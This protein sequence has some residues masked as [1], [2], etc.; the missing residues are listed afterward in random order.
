[1]RRKILIT[2]MLPVLVSIS[3]AAESKDYPVTPVPFTSVR[4]QDEFWFPRMET[5]RLVTVRADFKKCE[6]TGRIDNFAKAGGLMKGE[7]R[8]IPF[9]DSDVF[10]VIE[11]ASY[12]LAMHPDPELDKYL[13]EVIAK[14]AASQEPDGYLYTARKLI[15]PEKMPN[16]SGKERWFNEHSSHELYNVGHMY[17]GAVAHYQATGKRTFLDVAIKNADLICKEFGPGKHQNP[18]GHQEIEI[19]LCKL[20]RVTGQKKYL[21]TAKFLIDIRG[22]PETHKLYGGYAQDHKPVIEQDEAVG[23]AVRAGYL[24]SGMADVAAL[25]GDEAYLKAIDR[26]W[27]NVAFKKL[28]LTGGI[29]ARHGGEAFGD[30]YELPN[31]SAYNET[32]AAIANGLW[33]HRMFLLHGDAKYLDVLERVIYNGFLSGVEL[34]GDKFFYPNPLASEKGYKRSPWFGC[35]CCP[36]NIVRFIPSI[37]GYVY[38]VKEADLF[39]NLFIGGTGEIKMK[40]RV[41]KISQQTKYPW[42]G[43]VK[44][45]VDPEK[46]GKFGLNIRIPG[47]AQGRPVPGDLYKYL[48]GKNETGNVIRDEKPGIK[49][50][51]K[52]EE[53]NVRNGFAVMDREWAKGDVVELFLPMPIRRVVA[54]E[55]IKDDEGLVA[56][57]RGPVVYCLEG[58]DNNSVFSVVL[59]DDVKLSAEYRAD[60]LGGIVVI[61]GDVQV[62]VKDES[63]STATKPAGLLA[64]PYYSWCN[65]GPS[66]MNVWLAR[67]ADKARPVPAPTVASESKISASHLWQNDT[68][69][70]LNDQLMPKNSGD[71]EVPRFTWWDHKGTTEWVQYDF[72][73]LARVSSVEVYWFD[74]TGRGQCRVPESWKLLR[75]DGDSWKP[76]EGT[77]EYGVKKDCVNKATFTAVETTALRLEVRLQKDF[78]G[79][80]LEWKVE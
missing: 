28:Y 41:V 50:N 24:Y 39:V 10:K 56:I 1:M 77:P 17:E 69:I 57:E 67:T 7:F 13:D 31:K 32:C 46:A 33:N 61:R 8:G 38:A 76:V 23:H 21:D 2:V 30:N 16:M 58:T 59:A 63:G 53:L 37:A 25:T 35:A 64:I 44:I 19:G 45:T 15:P 40:D 60:M 79:G 47:W 27:E 68:G 65:R 48:E 5:N 11:G 71:H 66:Q 55:A 6:E 78:S 34:S 29:G 12:T 75:K 3:N 54:N 9:D 52:A 80:I 22:K 14:I 4:V 42:E 51:G 20:Y 49:I 74:D 26:I 62:A 18:P 36:V 73:K 70:A 72:A 43:F